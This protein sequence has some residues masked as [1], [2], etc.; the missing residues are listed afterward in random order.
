LLCCSLQSLLVIVDAQFSSIP[1]LSQTR[2]MAIPVRLGQRRDSSISVV[3]SALTCLHSDSFS[4][5][6][7]SDPQILSLKRRLYCLR[8]R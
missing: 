7:Q 2:H 1:F 3:R 5:S 6:N 4:P 8:V